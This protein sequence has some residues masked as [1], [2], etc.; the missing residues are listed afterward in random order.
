[1]PAPWIE[2]PEQ[3][4]EILVRAFPP[5]TIGGGKIDIAVHPF[6]NSVPV[7]KFSALVTDNCL[8]QL[9]R[10]G[11][12][13]RDNRMLHGLS[14]LVRSG[15]LTAMQKRVLRSARVA[16]QALLLHWP[17]TTVSASQCPPF[18][19]VHGFV[20]FTNRLALTA[21]SSRF[22]VSVAFPIALQFPFTRCSS[23]SQ[24]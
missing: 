14:P 22:L 18:P 16:K 5:G 20:P 6:L 23:Y 11:S 8:D 3:A 10:E 4:V 24:R 1:M 2:L 13:H 17:H 7:S 12:R 21:F 19:A 9:R 15:I